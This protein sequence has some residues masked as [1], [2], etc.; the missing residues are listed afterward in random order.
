MR[1]LHDSRFRGILLSEQFMYDKKVLHV[2]ST[3]MSSLTDVSVGFQQSCW[4]MMYLHISP[5]ILHMKYCP[6][7]NFGQG[8]CIFTSFHIP[9]SELYLLNSFDFDFHLFWITWHW[10]P[11]IGLAIS[12]RKTCKFLRLSLYSSTETNASPASRLLSFFCD[13]LYYWR[14]FTEYRKRL[15]NMVNAS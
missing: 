4:C 9:G 7:L 15:P 12:F 3:F 11:A 1:H 13:I 2:L 8:L 14:H 6:D 10:K 5:D